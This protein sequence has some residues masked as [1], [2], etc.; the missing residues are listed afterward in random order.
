[1]LASTCLSTTPPTPAVQVS[2]DITL[3]SIRDHMS[4][5]MRGSTGDVVASTSVER[6]VEEREVGC[7]DSCPCCNLPSFQLGPG[8]RETV[9]TVSRTVETITQATTQVVISN[10]GEEEAD[11]TLTA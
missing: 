2:G 11:T 7:L 3:D 6:T 10:G 4:T 5:T 9:E 1:M 8:R